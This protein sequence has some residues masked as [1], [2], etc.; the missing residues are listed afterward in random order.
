ME[1]STSPVVILQTPAAIPDLLEE[2]WDEEFISDNE[3]TEAVKA[4]SD[5]RSE[6]VETKSD[7]KE[8]SPESEDI[9]IEY[10]DGD[11]KVE[12]IEI[13]IETHV[14]I[15]IEN[16]EPSR[17]PKPLRPSPIPE[18]LTVRAITPESLAKLHSVV[19]KN[20]GNLIFR[21]VGQVYAK[22]ENLI[23]TVVTKV[24]GGRVLSEIIP[25]SSEVREFTEFEMEHNVIQRYSSFYFFTT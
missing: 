4:D 2:A 9:Y 8:L 21:R 23:E 16:P 18:T 6:D 10:E 7:Q 20:F 24:I 15:P 14:E 12:S 25:G 3:S 1:S 22:P 5:D 11:A 17:G 19:A 13:P